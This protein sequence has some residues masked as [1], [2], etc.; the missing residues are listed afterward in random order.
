MPKPMY[1]FRVIAI[2]E[3]PSLGDILGTMQTAGVQVLDCNVI[4]EE[5]VAP[6]PAVLPPRRSH[7]KQLTIPSAGRPTGLADA[8]REILEPLP[9][10]TMILR[11]DIFKEMVKRGFNKQS[12]GSGVFQ[13][14]NGPRFHRLKKGVYTVADVSAP[15]LSTKQKQSSGKP[16]RDSLSALQWIVKYLT[17]LRPGSKVTRQELMQAGVAAGF[18]GQNINTTIQTAYKKGL[19]LREGNG[20][21]RTPGVDKPTS[22]AP[23][24]SEPA[25]PVRPSGEVFSH[26]IEEA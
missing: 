24:V 6:A 12:I 14:L 4:A 17:P 8:I 10:G 21:Y 20:V 15:I 11:N 22:E 7:K 19:M 18:T 3:S 5:P 23:T 16:P 26:I 9:T 1:R 25:L 2:V 13:I